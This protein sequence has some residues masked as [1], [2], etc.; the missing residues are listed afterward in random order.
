M[1]GLVVLAELFMD[2]STLLF[3]NAAELDWMSSGRAT[4]KKAARFDILCFGDSMLKVGIAPRVL[5]AE[6]GRKV[7]NFAAPGRQAGPELSP[8]PT[9]DRGRAR[10]AALIVDF[11]LEG[12]NQAPGH[13]LTNPHWNALLA[14]PREAWEL[15]GN[16][17]DRE[18][19]P[20]TPWSRGARVLPSFRCRGQI[21]ETLL[22]VFQGQSGVNPENNRPLRRNWRVNGGGILLAKQPGFHG[23]VPPQWIGDLLSADLAVQPE[24][25]RWVRRLIRLA[26]EYNITVYWLLPPNSSKVIAAR[27]GNGVHARYDRFARGLLAMFPNLSVIDARHAGYDNS[28]FIDPVHL[29]RDGAVALS[30]AVADLLQ[31]ALSHSEAVPRWVDLPADLPAA[32][33]RCGSKTSTNRRWPCGKAT[34]AGSDDRWGGRGSVRAACAVL[35]RG[36]GRARLRRAHRRLFLAGFG[37]RLT[38]SRART[39]RGKSAARTLFHRQSR[40]AGRYCYLPAPSELDVRVAPHP[41]QSFTNAPLQDAAAFGCPLLACTWICRWQLACS[42]SMLSAVLGPPRLR[43]MR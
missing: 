34:T 11:A 18:F 20:A 9:R 15:A 19:F 2:R 42:N 43:Q 5:E 32:G 3:I 37:R 25:A 10:P 39:D 13:L 29:D 8:V 4:V 7:Y 41:A 38:R 12:L 14:S 6:L 27:D 24:N 35:S 40:V 21:R 28:L 17:H 26:A 22:T 1:L 31:N 16:Y 36:F 23:D 30:S 33:R